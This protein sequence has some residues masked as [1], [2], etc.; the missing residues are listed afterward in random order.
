MKKDILEKLEDLHKQAI[1]EHSHFYV[2]SVVHE[3]MKEIERLRE[4]EFM[5][6][7]CSK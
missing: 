3:A 7:S 6:K 4:F 5:Y 2:A 1:T